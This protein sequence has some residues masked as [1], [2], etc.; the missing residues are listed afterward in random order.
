M[1]GS[2]LHA[3]VKVRKAGQRRVRSARSGLK[4]LHILVDTDLH[5]SEHVSWVHIVPS[6]APELVMLIQVPRESIIERVGQQ[7]HAFN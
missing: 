5:I 4:H 7:P 2:S 1:K 3:A 6:R